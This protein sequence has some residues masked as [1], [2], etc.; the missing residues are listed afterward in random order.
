ML[1]SGS[2]C[3]ITT[4]ISGS[5]A[6]K[7]TYDDDPTASSKIEHLDH[8]QSQLKMQP[9]NQLELLLQG[10]GCTSASGSACNIVGLDV[11]PSSI[12]WQ[13]LAAAAAM[14]SEAQVELSK[15]YSSGVSFSPSSN[16]VS[17]AQ[18]SLH[19]EVDFCKSTDESPQ[20]YMINHSNNKQ[21]IPTAKVQE[22]KDLSKN[23][24]SFHELSCSNINLSAPNALTER[25]KHNKDKD[26]NSYL[27]LMQ[28]PRRARTAFTYEQI[29]LL[30]RRFQETKY[31][32]VFERSLLSKSLRLT[33]TQ[34]KIWFQ[35]RRTKWKKQNPG[36]ELSGDNGSS[37]RNNAHKARQEV[38]LTVNARDCERSSCGHVILSPFA[39]RHY[40]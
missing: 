33:E 16:R 19:Q 36:S 17:E 10:C 14:L 8:H 28:R 31:L 30:E 13:A 9:Q 34:V 35:N 15:L 26:K 22:A 3:G 5:L 12:D 2:S 38:M 24:S 27:A 40:K 25:Q 1:F 7:I 32:S 37:M 39:S 21:T 11:R 6:A 23:S 18:N 4:V 20:F 29:L